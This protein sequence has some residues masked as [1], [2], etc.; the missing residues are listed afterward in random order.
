MNRKQFIKNSALAAFSVSI[1]GSVRASENTFTT[2]CETTNDILG[3]FYRPNAPQRRSLLSEGLQ[4]TVI[5][6]K[7]NVFGPDCTT[8]LSKALVEIWH[9]DTTGKYDNDSEAFQQRARWYTDTKGAYSFQTIL[10]G[11]YKNGRLYRPAHIHF[12]IT[13]PDAPEL[14]SQVYF[15]G[16]PDIPADPWAS[17]PKA[18]LR[19]LPIF[20][21]GVAGALSVQF[22]IYLGSK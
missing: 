15:Q 2:N 4:G 11:K 3:P 21:D 1:F 14:I 18:A 17:S 5:K 13:H 10:P 20:P 6:L 19:T 22:D 9:C 8:P 12:R 7:G 16:D